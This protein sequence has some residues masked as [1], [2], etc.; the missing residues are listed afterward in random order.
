M[1]PAE[2][3]ARLVQTHIE[4]DDLLGEALNARMP[5]AITMGLQWLRGDILKV[6]ADLDPNFVV[7]E[8]D[9]L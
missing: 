9:E 6:I 2:M 8:D 3:I 4:I 7:Q 1:T 5:T